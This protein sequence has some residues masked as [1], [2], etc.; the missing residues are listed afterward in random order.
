MLL[1]IVEDAPPEHAATLADLRRAGW[2]A[3]AEELLKATPDLPR[4][5][6]AFMLDQKSEAIELAST[7]L[8]IWA[9]NPAVRARV[10]PNLMWTEVTDEPRLAVWRG[11][12][13]PVSTKLAPK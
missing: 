12:I 5:S 1:H 11:D 3:G 4:F 13:A 7:R 8:A 6:Q 2:L 9:H 10:V